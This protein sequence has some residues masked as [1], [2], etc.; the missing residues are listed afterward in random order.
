[1]LYLVFP[2]GSLC[3]VGRDAFSKVQPSVS[4]SGALPT[5]IVYFDARST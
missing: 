4:V 5:F 3:D 1:M 2:S